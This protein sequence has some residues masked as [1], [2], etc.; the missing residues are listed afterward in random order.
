MS[1]YKRI[2]SWITRC[3]FR[4]CSKYRISQNIHQNCNRSFIIL[5]TTY[6]KADESQKNNWCFV[7]RVIILYWKFYSDCYWKW[8]CVGLKTFQYA[9]VLV[10]L[11][12]RNFTLLVL[13]RPRCLVC[14]IEA[15]ICNLAHACF[16][17]FKK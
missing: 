11:W 7:R 3:L 15:A 1:D 4:G 8:F 10:N 6:L 9:L 5:C 17:W 12:W 2:K 16:L 13:K 14:P